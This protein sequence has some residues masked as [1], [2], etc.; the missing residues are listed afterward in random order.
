MKK[1]LLKV[2]TIF[3]IA[4]SANAQVAN[5]NTSAWG[6]EPTDTEW[7]S[8]NNST[9]GTGAVSPSNIVTA[10]TQTLAGG[11]AFSQSSTEVRTGVYS[12]KADFDVLT[13]TPKLQ[14]WRSNKNN[15]GNWDY[16]GEGNYKVSLYVKFV[17]TPSGSLKFTSQKK[18]LTTQTAVWDLSTEIT[19]A[20]WTLLE[21]VFPIVGTDVSTDYW[22]TV[23]FGPIPASGQVYIDDVVVAFDSALSTSLSK[24][25]GASVKA[26]NGFINVT[27]A[28]LDAVYSITGQQVTTSG[29]ASGVY[30]VKISKNGKQDAVKVVM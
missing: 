21:Y 28:N 11:E 7:T 4:F 15:E 25:E 3:L 22:S 29:L 8:G 12:M 23:S 19:T 20:D 10:W 5:F 30:I 9:G 6:F 17:G 16:T 1:K 18:D 24:I 27:G 14:T 2:S 13:V 26:E